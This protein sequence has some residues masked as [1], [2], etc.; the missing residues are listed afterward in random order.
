MPPSRIRERGSKQLF[1]IPCSFAPFLLAVPSF[2]ISE[3]KCDLQ[4]AEIA[5]I[6]ISEQCFAG[7][8][9]V[10]RGRLVT[11]QNDRLYQLRAVPARRLHLFIDRP[12]NIPHLR[13]RTEDAEITE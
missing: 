5:K 8:H 12:D 9:K 6:K 1:S 3:S 10:L 4:T 7:L 2:K 11:K 13:D